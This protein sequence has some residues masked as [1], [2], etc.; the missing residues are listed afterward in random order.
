[1][2]RYVIDAVTLLH[3]VDAELPIDPSHRLV[4]PNSIRS[5][6]LQLLLRDVRAGTRGEAAALATHERITA[7]KLRLLGDRMSRRTAWQLARR[8]GWD[9]LR[10]AEYL[11]VTRMQADALITVDPELAAAAREIVP[12]AA[13]DDL[14][15]RA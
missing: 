8:H 14:S 15:T 2:A 11:A 5:E 7:L 10:G 6:A 3:L 12:V 13:L 4:A 9:S 1:M